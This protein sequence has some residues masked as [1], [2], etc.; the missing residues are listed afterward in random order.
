MRI[1]NHTSVYSITAARK[2]VRR[3]VPF[4]ACGSSL[5]CYT[6]DAAPVRPVTT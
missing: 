4:H 3:D 1:D 6:P 2:P 5:S